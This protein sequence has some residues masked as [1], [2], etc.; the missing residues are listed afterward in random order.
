MLKENL[1]NLIYFFC[2]LLFS[3]SSS[4]LPKKT[5]NSKKI[6]YNSKVNALDSLLNSNKNKT[7][8][9]YNN[10][11]NLNNRLDDLFLKNENL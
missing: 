5:I 8:E 6:E 10:L 9:N 4:I 7:T 3:C 2:I 11:Q 1:K